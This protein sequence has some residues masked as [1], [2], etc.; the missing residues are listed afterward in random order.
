M[1]N[2]RAIP[3]HDT[4]LAQALDAVTMSASKRAEAQAQIRRAEA[5]IDGLE[6]IVRSVQL[7]L[8]RFSELNT[9]WRLNSTTPLEYSARLSSAPRLNQAV[10]NSGRTVT[11]VRPAVQQITTV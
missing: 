3:L 1:T 9:A 11:R 6:R 7:G 2:L 10:Q 8:L 4:S 5:M